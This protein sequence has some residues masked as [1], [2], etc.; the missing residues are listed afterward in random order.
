[1]DRTR[2]TLLMRVRNP[3]D[4]R[5]WGEFVRLYEPLL[6]ASLRHHGLAAE[7]KPQ[8]ATKLGVGLP[9]PRRPSEGLQGIHPY[10]A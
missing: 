9:I 4:A 6:R 8:P 3:A 1:M 5:A 7:D 2:S 10:A